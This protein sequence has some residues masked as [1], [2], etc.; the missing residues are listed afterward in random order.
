MDIQIHPKISWIRNTAT[1]SNKYRVY[2]EQVY[3]HS[4]VKLSWVDT[5][6]NYLSSAYTQFAGK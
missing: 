3:L 1:N 4:K 5:K 2:A 6:Y